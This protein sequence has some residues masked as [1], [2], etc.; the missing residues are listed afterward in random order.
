MC[1][2]RHLRSTRSC[3][4]PRAAAIGSRRNSGWRARKTLDLL[5]PSS[6]SSE[7]TANTSAPPSATMPAAL[8][9][10]RPLHPRSVFTSA[11]L[12]IQGRSGWRRMVPVAVQGASSSTNG[13][14]SFGCEIA[15]IALHASRRQ[16]AA[17]PDFARAAAARMGSR[18][19]AITFAPAAASCTPCRPARRKDRS[20]SCRATSPS[21]R[22]GRLAAKSC[23]HQSPSAKPGSS[24]MRPLSRQPHACR[25]AACSPSG[26]PQPLTSC[27]MSSGGV[28]RWAAA[29]SRAVVSPYVSHQRDHS[30][31]GVFEARG[32]LRCRSRP[33]LRVRP[34]A[35]RR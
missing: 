29:M 31:S 34:A 19:T 30:Q 15:H 1:A 11:A 17:A 14:R 32:V 5:P 9:A 26:R 2:S 7:Q 3:R 33:R 27:R 4:T 10:F 22:A 12:L 23:T 8:P 16:A 20:P 13:A 18:S 35:A 21:S 24:S 6:G 25:R 28:A